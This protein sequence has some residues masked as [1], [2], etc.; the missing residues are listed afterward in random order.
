MRKTV[1]KMMTAY[2]I[3][4]DGKWKDVLIP[5]DG[6]VIPVS[7]SAWHIVRGRNNSNFVHPVALALKDCGFDWVSIA[8]VDAVAET[9][10]VIAFIKFPEKVSRFIARTWN[11]EKVKPFNFSAEIIAVLPL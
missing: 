6:S 5:G 11:G 10:D 4:T 9:A 7:V 3:C 8:R 1:G 2:R